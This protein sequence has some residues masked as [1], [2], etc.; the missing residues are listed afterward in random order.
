[1]E[2][3]PAK[4]TVGVFSA[5]LAILVI[6]TIRGPVTH[7]EAGDIAQDGEPCIGEPIEVDYAYDYKIMEPH[8]CKPQCTDGKQRYILYTNGLATQCEMLPGCN[9]T[10]EDRRVTC[11][12]PESASS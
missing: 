7:G 5:F 2:F 12:V 9:D 1:M 3:D 11:V 6:Q 8:A 10:G 4:A